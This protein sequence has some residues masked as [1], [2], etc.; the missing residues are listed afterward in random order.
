[1]TTRILP[2]EEW[3]RLEGTLLGEAWESLNPEKDLVLVLEQDGE[4]VACTSFLPRWHM[5]GTW[6]APQHRKRSGVGRAFLRGMHQMAVSLGAEELLMVSL[7]PETSALCRR[8]GKTS[9]CLHGE[10]YAIGL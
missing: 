8:L 3:P 7:D 5:E 4:I 6:V 10:H 9:T 1:M 2:V